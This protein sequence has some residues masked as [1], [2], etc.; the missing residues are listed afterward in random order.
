MRD[1]PNTRFHLAASEEIPL[2]DSSQDF[3][4]SLGVLHHIPDTEMAMRDCV[5]KLKPGAPFL[6]YLYYNFDNRPGWFRALWKTTDI[7]RRAICRLPFPMRKAIT[8]LLAALIYWPFARVAGLLA[9]IGV[10]IATFPLSTYR[11]AS[12][13]T[14]RTDALDRFGTR[15]ER[16]F[17]RAEIEAMMGRCGLVQIVFSEGTPHWVACGIKA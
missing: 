17:S 4:Y 15:L 13:Y 1:H 12:F 11:N 6:V 8:N 5:T 16:R 10:P 14:M 9:K 2:E 7:G 3:G